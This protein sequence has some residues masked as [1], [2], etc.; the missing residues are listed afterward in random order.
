MCMSSTALFRHTCLEPQI[1][2]NRTTTVHTHFQAQKLH[3]KTKEFNIRCVQRA[4]NC[5]RPRG[6]HGCAVKFHFSESEQNVLP[7]VQGI[8]LAVPHNTVT[9]TTTNEP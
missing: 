4:E 9:H 5:I 2:G 6:K 7:R 1:M 8:Q 3:C